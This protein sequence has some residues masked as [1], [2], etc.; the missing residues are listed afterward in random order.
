MNRFFFDIVSKTH[1]YHDFRG[2]DFARPEEARELA[3]L[4]AL[5]LECTESGD[6]AGSEILVR[7]I[8]GEQLFYVRVGEPDL[9]AA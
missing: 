8:K 9:M 6:C 3:D 7:D 5:D 1:V 2:R 4:I